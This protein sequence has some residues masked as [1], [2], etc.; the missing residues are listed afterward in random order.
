MVKGDAT[1]DEKDPRNKPE[2]K[3]AKNPFGFDYE[4]KCK[5]KMLDLNSQRLFKGIKKD[6][7]NY[8]Q[9]LKYTSSGRISYNSPTEFNIGYFNHELPDDAFSGMVIGKRRTGKSHFTKDFVIN[10]ADR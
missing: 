2:I 7:T 1:E 5:K 8:S 4:L 3:V 6:W 10:T 9:K